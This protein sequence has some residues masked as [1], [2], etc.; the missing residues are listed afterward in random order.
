MINRLACMH[1]AARLNVVMRLVGRRKLVTGKPSAFDRLMTEAGV[2]DEGIEAYGMQR[3]DGD[4]K[5]QEKNDSEA[6]VDAKLPGLRLVEMLEKVDEK[7]CRGCGAKFQFEDQRKEGY[8]DLKRLKSAENGVDANE[9]LEKLAGLGGT[10]D[11]DKASEL[12][13]E[14]REPQ[15]SSDG[16]MY[17]VEDYEND[18]VFLDSIKEVEE[19]FEDKVIPKDICDRCVLINNSK[20]KE[21]REIE[22]NIESNFN[23]N[24]E[25]P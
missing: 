1:S 24:K 15:V 9:V 10:M 21:L 3:F 19:I 17:S 4:W 18:P 12:Y 6:K 23:F 7:Q 11:Q 2:T 22:I 13:E 20:Y 5:I 16:K 14:P 25:F 8:I